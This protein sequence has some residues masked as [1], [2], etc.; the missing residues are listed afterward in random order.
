MG[1][2]AVGLGD[3][4]HPGKVNQFESEIE[5]KSFDFLKP[6]LSLHRVPDEW[7]KIIETAIVRSML[8]TRI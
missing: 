2:V 6:I 3:F 4:L 1:V 5:N 8:R 7:Q